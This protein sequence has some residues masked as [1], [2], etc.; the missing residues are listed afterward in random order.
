MAAMPLGFYLVSVP[1]LYLMSLVSVQCTNV[2]EGVFVECRDRYLWVSI[3]KW[4]ADR[5]VRIDAVDNSGAYP[6]TGKHS[7]ECG[8]THASSLHGHKVYRASYLSC[9]TENQNDEVFVF[10]FNFI[11]IDHDGREVPVDMSQ[12]CTLPLPWSAR[13]VI[14]ESNYME[15]SVRRDVPCTP[16][17]GT[18]QETWNTAISVAHASATPAWKVVFIKAGEE[19]SSMP[20]SDARILGYVIDAT[21]ERIV[22]RAAYAKSHAEIKM[23]SGI[24]VE[25]IHATVFFR[26]KWMVVVMDL[27]AAC[28]SNLG[29]W[30]FGGERLVW[31]TPKVM[32]PL[33]YN[34]SGFASA[35]IRLGVDAWLLD[36]STMTDWGYTLDVSEDLVSIG[37]PYA[38]KGG[39]RLSFVQHNLYHEYYSVSLYYE[40]LFMDDGGTATRLRHVQRMT[41]PLLH[42]VPFTIDQTILEEHTFTVYLGNIP[43]DVELAEVNLNGEPFTV[44]EAIQSGYPI[45]KVPHS[46]GTHAYVIRVPFEDSIVPKLYSS[47]GILQYS[48]AINYTLNI[49]PRGD[50]YYYSASVIAQIMDVFPPGFNGVCTKKSIIFKMD[51]KKLGYLWEVGIGHYPLTPKLAAHRGYILQNNSQSLTLEVPVFTIGYTYEDISLR[52][53]FGTF[54]L[55]SRDAKTLQIQKSTAKRCLFRTDEL[56]VCSPDGIMTVV[57]SVAAVLPVAEPIRA[58]L[59]DATCTPKEVDDIRVLFA[60]G[61]NT[62]GTTV[63]VDDSYVSYE[64]EILINRQFLPEEAPVITR[65]ADFRLTVQCYY[66]VNDVNRLFVDQKFKSE[67]PGFGSITQTTS[68]PV[69]HVPKTTP[70]DVPKTTPADVPKTTPPDVP[71]Q[72][73]PSPS[74]VKTVFNTRAPTD[75]GTVTYVRLVSKSLL[76]S[77]VDFWSDTSPEKAT[78]N[79]TQDQ[80]HQVNPRPIVLPPYSSRTLH[81]P[82]FISLY[83]AVGSMQCNWQALGNRVMSFPAMAPSDFYYTDPTLA[84]G[85]RVPNVLTQ[86]E[87]LECGQLNTPPPVMS[88]IPA[89]PL[90]PDP[91]RTRPHPTRELGSQVWTWDNL[92]TFRSRPAQGR[93]VEAI[94]LSMEEDHAITNLMTLHYQ[95]QQGPTSIDPLGRMATQGLTVEDHQF[96]SQPTPTQPSFSDSGPASNNVG[97]TVTSLSM[98]ECQSKQRSDVE[99]EAA[100]VLLSLEDIRTD[101]LREEALSLSQES[102]GNHDT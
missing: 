42:Q 6:I 23:V 101:L 92:S 95:S 37:I 1:L 9:H 102:S 48:L 68:P 72:T 28:T 81:H 91:F 74:T 67:T 54:E 78:A 7:S 2:P 88:I 77:M 90:E 17:E 31:E 84:P 94:Q 3:E 70:A 80:Q 47:E 53:F 76:F 33:I 82:S 56:I 13:E 24:P 30:S 46:D 11:I 34:H 99:M 61:V 35:H 71:K 44:A 60:F 50:S 65:D 4:F 97:G 27:T 79:G 64:N 10:N 41:S 36:E 16:G 49:M 86:L 45:T 40:H 14:C 20:I 63:T 57:A 98:L 66:P 75:F 69:K 73:M 32:T 96:L 26:Q 43:Y 52:Q 51:H 29:F 85:N 59:L 100:S 12:T 8:Y 93:M 15:V 58:T 18:S 62:C 25:V 19:V 21:V 55:L 83:M 89:L 22:F 38:A 5:I 87:A 39:Y